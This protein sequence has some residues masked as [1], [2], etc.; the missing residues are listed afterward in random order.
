[1]H[2]H[3]CARSSAAFARTSAVIGWEGGTAWACC[4]HLPLTLQLV[5]YT[6]AHREKG[7]TIPHKEWGDREVRCHA[8]DIQL[9]RSLQ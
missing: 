3:T 7:R 6:A 5:G 1:M 2:L 9:I 8:E 4:A